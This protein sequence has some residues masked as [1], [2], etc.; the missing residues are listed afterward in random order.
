M[1]HFLMR[2]EKYDSCFIFLNKA[3]ELAK[4]SASNF[5]NAEGIIFRGMSVNYY[6]VANYEKML[7]FAEKTSAFFDSTQD[8]EMQFLGF[9]DEANAHFYLG[10]FERALEK[11]LRAT[12]LYESGKVN[13]YRT[14][15]DISRIYLELGQINKANQNSFIF[16]EQ[17]KKHNNEYDLTTAY[18]ELARNHLVTNED[19]IALGFAKKS[20]Q[21]NNDR[22]DRNS[23]LANLH[24][25]KA[26]VKLFNPKESLIYAIQAMEKSKDNPNIVLRASLENNLGYVYEKL[27][28]F[29]K[30]IE[31]YNNSLRITL[32]SG[33]RNLS[34]K[35]YL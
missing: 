30:S 1:P 35:S 7:E 26:L 9:L 34:M 3:L 15:S 18:L 20:L 28:D 6:K 16:L 33:Y 2:E 27:G 11:Q 14:Y 22:F 17:A 4:L 25:S 19:S 21:I 10:N 5:P 24:A 31:H 29:S 32:K 23:T 12:K 13:K 8:F